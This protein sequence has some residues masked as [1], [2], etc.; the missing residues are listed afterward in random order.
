MAILGRQSGEG[1]AQNP[2]TLSR[3]KS[4]AIDYHL[5]QQQQQQLALQHHQQQH[6]ASEEV[7]GDDDDYDDG[8]GD[9]EEGDDEDQ[10]TSTV[11]SGDDG[12]EGDHDLHQQQ[13]SDESKRQWEAGRVD[14]MGEHQSDRIIN[15]LKHLIHQ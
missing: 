9:G 4:W 3:K 14:W 5:Q 11:V 2:V 1:S 12:H 7:D 8:D 10:E 6:S 13:R 15:R